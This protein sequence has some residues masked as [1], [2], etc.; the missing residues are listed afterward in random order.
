[1]LAQALALSTALPEPVVSLVLALSLAL[2]EPVLSLLLLWPVT[3]RPHFTISSS[4][5]Y[6]LEGK[7]AEN[8]NFSETQNNSL[9]IPAL[10]PDN[11]DQSTSVMESLSVDGS[12][13]GGLIL[14][15]GWMQ[16]RDD[17]IS[18]TNIEPVHYYHIGAPEHIG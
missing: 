2:S 11:P 1:M 6:H 8:P 3:L 18:Q 9:L 14:C 7:I 16:A 12:C 15:E 10:A 5:L 4:S 17:H 13:T